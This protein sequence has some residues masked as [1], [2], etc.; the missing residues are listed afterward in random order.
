MCIRDRLLFGLVKKMILADRLAY[1][2]NE[3]FNN[4]SSYSGFSILFGFVAYTFCL[5]A[6]FSG[7]I[8]IVSGV[9]RLFGIKIAE[10][11]RRPFF[12]HTVQE[13]WRNC[14]N[15]ILSATCRMAH[16][17]HLARRKRKICCLRLVLFRNNL[18]RSTV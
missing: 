6:D 14:D 17:G 8:D 1:I 2:S 4:Y 16:Y 11:F 12:S 10:N 5:Y 13:F 3:V 7:F 15:N 9:S 18:P